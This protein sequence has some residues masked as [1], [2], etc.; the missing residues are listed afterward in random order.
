MCITSCIHCLGLL[1]CSRVVV[2]N[3]YPFVKTI[4][5]DNVTYDSAV[6]NIDIGGVT[7]LRAAAKNH[8]RVTVL[9]DPADYRRL[10]SAL[11]IDDPIH[12]CL[13]VI[14]CNV[15]VSILQSYHTSKHFNCC[16]TIIVKSIIRTVGPVQ[17]SLIACF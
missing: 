7:L 6:E 1:F 5:A 4:S 2:C 16:V 13:F 15:Y 12:C 10:N 8:Q 9:C 3:L 17:C 11:Y 14:A